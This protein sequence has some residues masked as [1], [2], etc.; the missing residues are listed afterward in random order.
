MI[1]KYQKIIDNLLIRKSY[2]NFFCEYCVKRKW[3]HRRCLDNDKTIVTI[4]PPRWIPPIT[5]NSLWLRSRDSREVLFFRGFIRWY[6]SVSDSWLPEIKG[7]QK[8]R[9]NAESR[10]ISFCNF[11]RCSY[12]NDM[13]VFGSPKSLI[14]LKVSLDLRI[15]CVSW[16]VLLTLNLIVCILFLYCQI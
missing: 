9:L 4:A 6:A 3:M 15:A 11:W 8:I 14:F 2:F 7:K 1:I 10:L 12:G 13:F 16:H 5:E